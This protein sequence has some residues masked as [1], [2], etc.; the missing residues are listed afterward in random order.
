MCASDEPK[1]LN[2]R[3][4]RNGKLDG[5]KSMVGTDERANCRC[6]QTPDAGLDDGDITPSVRKHCSQMESL[7]LSTFQGCRDV[8]IK[9]TFLL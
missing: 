3:P 8:Q 9:E 5:M 6:P 2:P 1:H 7:F 4:Y